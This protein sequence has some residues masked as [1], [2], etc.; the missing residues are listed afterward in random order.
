MSECPKK[1][2][3]VVESSINKLLLML[4]ILWSNWDEMEEESEKEDC[5]FVLEVFCFGK[6]GRIE[7]LT[8]RSKLFLEMQ[9]PRG[10]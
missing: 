5:S 9:S 4:L 10:L 2:E 6:E 1:S 7:D 3:S 8:E